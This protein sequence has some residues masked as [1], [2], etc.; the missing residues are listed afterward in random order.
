WRLPRAVMPRAALAAAGLGFVVALAG[1]WPVDAILLPASSP[2]AQALTANMMRLMMGPAVIFSSS[3]LLMGILQS[4]GVFLMPS[5]AISMNSI[6]II[7]GALFIA[8]ALPP[9]E[10]MG[11]VGENNVY[12]LA[13]GA[14]LS[15][16]LHLVVQLPGLRGI[17][18]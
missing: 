16:L 13:I 11:Q 7:I 18:S 6:G 2:E 8:P 1:P 3:G 17:Q 5:L 4:H 12:G 14:V 10:G 15:A 9:L